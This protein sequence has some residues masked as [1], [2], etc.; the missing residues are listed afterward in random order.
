M[1]DVPLGLTGRL[2]LV[3]APEHT[4]DTWK[5]AGVAVLATPML[6]YWVEAACSLAI[7]VALSDGEATLGTKLSIEHLRATP[8][9][10][11]VGVTATLVGVEGRRLTFE[12]EAHDEVE[13][14]A[15]ATHE[16]FVVDLERFLRSVSAKS[17]ATG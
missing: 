7:Q 1:R 5:N 17:V 13:P 6:C 15:R 12:C 8:V 4:A 14:I 3:V 10:M 11:R 9:G 2:D 16:R